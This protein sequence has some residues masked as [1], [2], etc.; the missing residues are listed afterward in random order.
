MDGSRRVAR[1]GR[2]DGE[3][4]DPQRASALD[5]ASPPFALISATR[6]SG[7]RCARPSHVFRSR[8]ASQAPVRLLRVSAESLA[9][10]RSWAVPVRR[11]VAGRCSGSRPPAVRSEAIPALPGLSPSGARVRVVRQPLHVAVLHR[12]RP[13]PC[14]PG[15]AGGS[16]LQLESATTVRRPRQPARRPSSEAR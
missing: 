3:P 6:P 7:G 8:A 1:A 16:A 9:G 12:L 10:G 4:P 2:K 11:R 14:R 5:R 15:Y 13:L